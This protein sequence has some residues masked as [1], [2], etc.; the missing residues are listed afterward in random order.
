MTRELPPIST[1][2]IN[3]PFLQRLLGPEPKLILEIGANR[4]MHTELFL[5]TF[6]TARIHAFEPDPRA[7]EAFRAR[8]NDPRATLHEL[9]VGATNGRAEFHVSSG[10]PPDATPS[11]Q[12]QY[13]KGWDQSGSLRTPKAHREKWPWCRFQRTIRVEVRTLDTWSRKHEPGPVDF[14]WADMQ[15]AEADLVAGGAET[16][17]RTRYFYTECFDDELYEGAPRLGEL[18]DLLPAF[19]IVKRYESEVLLRN[20]AFASA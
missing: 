5:R 20:T 9:A 4:G 13:P 12:A 15:G 6:P 18:L 11:M 10:M 19:E 16:L 3:G 8:I 14:I 17:A 1:V 2:P 7:I